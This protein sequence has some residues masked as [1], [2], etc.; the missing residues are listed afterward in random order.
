MKEFQTMDSLVKNFFESPTFVKPKLAY[1]D[2]IAHTI[3]NNLKANDTKKLLSSVGKPQ[4]DLDQD[5]AFAS[6]M[7]II[8]VEDRNGKRYCITVE[9]A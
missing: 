8:Y 9:E 3:V 5:G 6:T 4:Y 1:C 7:K 2:Y